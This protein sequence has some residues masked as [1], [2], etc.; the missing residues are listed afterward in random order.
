MSEVSKQIFF[1]YSF[2]DI[3]KVKEIKELI[4]KETIF[5]VFMASDLENGN[6]YGD[7]WTDQEKIA[8][9]KSFC[10]ILFVS[11]NSVSSNRVLE[12]IEHYIFIKSTF[13][14]FKN[15]DLLS[16][17]LDG[18]SFI[19]KVD[20]LRRKINRSIVNKIDK[21]IRS[22]S[23]FDEEV[24]F[25]DLTHPNYNKQLIGA[26]EADYK[27]Y[28]GS[29]APTLALKTS[30]P[31]K[32]NDNKFAE[33]LEYYN[34]KDYT[35]AIPLF[36]ELGNNNYVDA[37]NYLC[38][39]YFNLAVNYEKGSNGK[40][41]F[42]LAQKYYG[43]ASD[44]G[45]KEAK[46]KYEEL[47]NKILRQEQ[48]KKYAEAKK[49]YDAQEYTKSFPLFLE[50]G[51]NNYG[52]AYFYLGYCYKNGCGVEKNYEEA[53]KWYQ[54]SYDFGCT[55]AI[56]N[57]GICYENGQGVKKNIDKAIELYELAIKKC[58]EK[59]AYYNLAGIYE[60]GS[61]GK[62]D[63]ELAQENYKKA[64]DLGYETAK[65]KYEELSNKILRQE[66]DK[67]YAE[68]KK[69]YNDKEYTKAFPIFLELGN[70]NYVD[71][72]NYL[73]GCYQYGRG[74]EEN[75]NE[76]YK[77][78]QK[79]IENRDYKSANSLAWEYIYGSFI[80]KGEEVEYVSV[81]DD[82]DKAIELYNLALEFK[83]NGDSYYG[84]GEIYEKEYYGKMD[85]ELAAKYYKKAADLGYYLAELKLKERKIKK[86]LK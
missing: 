61:N 7:S 25:V 2:K 27:T 21:I 78:Y 57:L 18:S 68:A 3:E 46:K 36:L 74:V 31:T 53:F 77:W 71:A 73:G 59:Y 22:T 15:M 29:E 37:Y 48:D 55:A 60:N 56:N 76:S 64:A 28:N 49:Y 51:N 1:S 65:K 24:L 66:Q 83:E 10:V 79:G 40:I 50:L 70:N 42:E 81:I 11:D 63:L 84:L 5:T 33:A 41:D 14:N 44:L 69:Y 6:H 32:T 85:L 75:Y 23:C 26:L 12:E 39:C 67:K 20:D 30:N 19:T 35:K 34:A 38:E 9:E 45:H 54:K 52:N 58:N 43:M 62:V 80:K 4:E 17:S 47:S 13:R 86:Y 8:M 72:Y 82:I 16:V